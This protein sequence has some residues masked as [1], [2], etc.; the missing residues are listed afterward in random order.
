MSCNCFVVSQLCGRQVHTCHAW[1]TVELIWL[2]CMLFASAVSD[3]F[4]DLSFDVD[5]YDAACTQLFGVHTQYNW[6]ATKYAPSVNLPASFTSC[7]LLACLLP[8]CTV[9]CMLSLCPRKSEVQHQCK[10]FLSTPASIQVGL[11]TIPLSS[12]PCISSACS[13][14]CACVHASVLH[15]CPGC[16]FHILFCL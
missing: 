1:T 10:P 7:S 12:T 3:M 11:H 6:A 13:Y 14:A 16:A 2:D 9:I 4:L 5:L 8:P 15:A